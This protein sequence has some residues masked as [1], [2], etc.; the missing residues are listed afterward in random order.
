MTEILLEVPNED[1]KALIPLFE[2]LGL[3][4]SI[5]ERTNIDKKTLQVQPAKIVL[6][7]HLAHIMQEDKEL[8]QKLA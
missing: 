5:K 2:R 4:F 7:R 6:T 3:S 8:L 1:L